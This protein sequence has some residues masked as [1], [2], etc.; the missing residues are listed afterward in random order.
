MSSQEFA[1]FGIKFTFAA[2]AIIL[3]VIYLVRPVI[4]SLRAKPDFLESMNRYE[5]PVE[6]EAEIE[7]PTEGTWPD[8]STMLEQARADPRTAAALISQWLKQKK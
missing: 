4:R 7:I 8:R 6:D 3:I 5:L 1:I 2:A